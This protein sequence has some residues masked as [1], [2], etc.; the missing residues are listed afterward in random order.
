MRQFLIGLLFILATAAITS[1]GSGEATVL[2]TVTWTFG[3]TPTDGQLTIQVPEEWELDLIPKDD[4]GLFAWAG[5][6]LSVDPPNGSISQRPRMTEEDWE[7]RRSV[8]GNRPD[9]YKE[10][11]HWEGTVGGAP[12][13]FEEMVSMWDSGDERD[14]SAFVDRGEHTWRVSCT[15]V[16]GDQQQRDL[17]LEVVGS[18]RFTTDEEVSAYE[19]KIAEWRDSD[20][21]LS[22][23]RVRPSLRGD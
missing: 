18:L 8:F 9:Y 17:C 4:G 10:V 19:T 21:P 2:K 3:D 13:T 16:A 20:Q 5:V 15:S 14:L 6:P 11:K 7:E 12:A 23:G 22:V 1:C